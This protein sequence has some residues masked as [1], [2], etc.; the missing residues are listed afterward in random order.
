MK[1]PSAGKFGQEKGDG[2]RV[3]FL[4]VAYSGVST[5]RSRTY[6]LGLSRKPDA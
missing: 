1:V 4:M 3:D 5:T 6:D 2:T